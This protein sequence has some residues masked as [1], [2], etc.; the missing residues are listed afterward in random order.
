[1]GQMVAISEISLEL[2]ETTFF[3]QT[4]ETGQIESKAFASQNNH[5]NYYKLLRCPE[6]FL[7]EIDKIYS[8]P[9]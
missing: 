8:F 4:H 1:M 2:M 3:H 6:V 5:I 9:S 7:P